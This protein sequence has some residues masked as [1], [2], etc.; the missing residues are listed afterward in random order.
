[1]N[2][3][4]IGW[5]IVAVELLFVVLVA[6]VGRWYNKRDTDQDRKLREEFVAA[7]DKLLESE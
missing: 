6:V 3:P 7:A 1:M 2:E 4:L 5:L